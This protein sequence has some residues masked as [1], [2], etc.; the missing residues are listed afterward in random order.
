MS[1]P[2]LGE[3]HQ[4]SRWMLME[5]TSGYVG[6][7]LILLLNSWCQ[8]GPLLDAAQVEVAESGRYERGET[9]PVAAKLL[10]RTVE[11][12]DDGSAD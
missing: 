4:E 2:H 9:A 1:G 11:E 12:G 10:R 3:E 7:D 5:Q 6:F 8:I